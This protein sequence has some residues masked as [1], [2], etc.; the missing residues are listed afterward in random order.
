[1][2][3]GPGVVGWDVIARWFDKNN[4]PLT[5]DVLVN[6]IGFAG[7][8]MASSVALDDLGNSVIAWYDYVSKASP[9]MVYYRQFDRQ[10]HA[11]G[12]ERPVNQQTT[13]HQFYGHAGMADEGGFVIT[14]TSDRDGSG[15]GVVAQRYDRFG[16]AA[17]DEV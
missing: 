16:N 8:Q 5:A 17:G 7:D 15:M 11:L 10:G 14:W 6:T 9:A 1:M 13:D 2:A 12:A 3:S 4:S